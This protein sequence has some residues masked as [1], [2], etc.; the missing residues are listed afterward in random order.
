MIIA[1]VFDPTIYPHVN[2]GPLA[3]LDFYPHKPEAFD[4]VFKNFILSLPQGPQ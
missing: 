2:Q 1:V 4:Q 3:N